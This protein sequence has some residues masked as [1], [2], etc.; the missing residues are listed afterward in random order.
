[1]KQIGH[2]H[3]HFI[4]KKQIKVCCP[5]QLSKDA[6]SLLRVSAPCTESSAVQKKICLW[7]NHG[8]LGQFKKM[9]WAKLIPFQK[10]KLQNREMGPFTM[11]YKMIVDR[12][13]SLKW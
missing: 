6:T 13:Q 5:K 11:R 1:M 8:L 7:S 9:N 2:S 12:G 4:D 10:F 3:A